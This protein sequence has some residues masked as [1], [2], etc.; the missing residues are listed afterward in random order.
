MINIVCIYTCLKDENKLN[1]FKN[2]PLYKKLIDSPHIVLEVYSNSDENKQIGNKLFLRGNDSYGELSIKTYEMIS[3]CV[4]NYKFDNI[5]KIDSSLCYDETLET[6]SWRKNFTPEAIEKFVERK[7]LNDY[8]G[9]LNT[10]VTQDSFKQWA[11]R[12]KLKVSCVK[13]L[14][15]STTLNRFYL[16]KCYSISY[17]FASY[18]MKKYKKESY[19]YKERYGGIEDLFIGKIYYNFRINKID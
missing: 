10:S 12:K 16:G 15:G 11:I 8:D 6:E 5:I 13:S 4:K 9:V 19:L 2:T 18:I 17:K 3:Y 1:V 7:N 14:I